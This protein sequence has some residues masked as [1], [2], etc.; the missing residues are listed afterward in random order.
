MAG[1]TAV[2]VAV[3][4]QPAAGQSGD[5]VVIA[6]SAPGRLGVAAPADALRQYLD[7]LG[8]WRDRRRGELDRLDEASLRATDPDSYTGDITL[9]MALWQSC[10]DRY[11]QLVAAWDSGRA[12][13]L[14]RERMSQLIW[15][16]LDAGGGLGAGLA[17]SLVDACRLSDALAAQLRARLSFDPRAADAVARVA[18]LR[19]SM[20]RLR[21]LAEQEPGAVGV[22]Q[23]LAARVED[24]AGAA[25]R[26]GD[27]S[28]PLGLLEADA[29]RAERDLIVST[30]TRREAERDRE[31]QA[32]DL[33]RD[34]VRAMNEAAALEH[35][36]QTLIALADRCVHRIT[37][38][39]RLAVPEPEALGPVPTDRA[40][41]DAYLGRLSN[42][43]RA[44]DIVER[45]YSAPL[46]ELEELTGRL[47]GYRVMAA[48]T[49]RDTDRQ[50]QAAAQLA[51]SAL[52]AVPCDLDS[53]R[54]LVAQYQALIR[55]TPPRDAGPPRGTGAPGTGR[56]G[57][58]IPPTPA[59]GSP[60]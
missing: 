14:A 29:A 26:G 53:A 11:E 21:A 10:S 58:A 1:G 9:C 34:R 41:L 5:G 44:M 36:Q 35:R 16:R 7:Q 37:L 30:A 33:V 48:R 15:G 6:P 22:V 28:G 12:D 31:R 32:A 51:R 24:L 17:V 57:P 20:E 47:A 27:V 54:T 39:P 42:V 60:R 4:A 8:R 49:G 55:A 38:A 19:A 40:G 23:R 59:P 52:Q 56:D 50:V 18:A 25:A 3:T 43:A 46:E 45:T 2:V 13:Q